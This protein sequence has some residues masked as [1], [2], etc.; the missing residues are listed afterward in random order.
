ME[1]LVISVNRVVDKKRITGKKYWAEEYETH[2]N[3][4]FF[5]NDK[6]IQLSTSNFSGSRWRVKTITYKI[7]RY[8]TTK[9]LTNAD[10]DNEIKK[11]LDVW[12]EYTDLN[13]EMKT[14]GQVL[15]QIIIK[16][17]I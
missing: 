15:L 14:S 12:S 17:L 4:D 16:R 9:R 5:L 7:S 3:H 13:F 1:M 10:V 11:A 2:K 6:T 8:P